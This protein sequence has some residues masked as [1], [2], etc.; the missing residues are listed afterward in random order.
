MAD[1]GPD[2]AGQVLDLW[3]H[4]GGIAIDFIRPGKP[5]ENALIDLATSRGLA[6]PGFRSSDRLVGWLQGMEALR[7]V[8]GRAT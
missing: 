1:H 7:G 5:I 6:F 2:S 8:V 3:V 4:Q